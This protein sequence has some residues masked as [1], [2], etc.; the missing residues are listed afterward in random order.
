[1][2]AIDTTYDNEHPT[3]RPGDTMPSPAPQFDSVV[4]EVAA[5]PRVAKKLF[6]E[7]DAVKAYALVG[8]DF[9]SLKNSNPELWEKSWTQATEIVEGLTA[10]RDEVSR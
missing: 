6:L 2:E 4:F 9:A 7:H 1:M 3:V 5:V 8:S 10:I